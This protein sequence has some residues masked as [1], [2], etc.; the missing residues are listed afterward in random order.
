MG[1][2]K[3][4]FSKEKFSSKYKISGQVLARGRFARIKKC[5]SDDEFSQGVCVKEV[6][7]SRAGKS[8][9]NDI[10]HEVT[11]LQMA[12]SQSVANV[13]RILDAFDENRYY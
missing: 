9:Q 1:D 13:L 4:V 11:I 5:T 8:L 10:N 3:P 2:L 12:K 6:M 7:K